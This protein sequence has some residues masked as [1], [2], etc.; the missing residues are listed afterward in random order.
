MVV[1]DTACYTTLGDIVDS[2]NDGAE[3]IW[4]STLVLDNSVLVRYTVE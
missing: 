1:N 2:G 4:N 3:F